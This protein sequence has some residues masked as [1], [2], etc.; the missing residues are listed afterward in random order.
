MSGNAI[1]AII[2]VLALIWSPYLYSI[3]GKGNV[4]DE[5]E[6]EPRLWFAIVMTVI[7]VLA[8]APSL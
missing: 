2:V 6:K 8:M 5:G 7:L 4:N 1:F 3:S